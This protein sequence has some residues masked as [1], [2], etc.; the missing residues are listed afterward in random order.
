MSGH[1]RTGGP[2]L[3]EWL[4]SMRNLSPSSRETAKGEG[5]LKFICSQSTYD[6]VVT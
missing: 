4:G 3:S 6:A 1:A 5:A 2:S